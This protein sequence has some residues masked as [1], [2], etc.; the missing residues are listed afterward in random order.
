MGRYKQ[1][2]VWKAGCTSAYLR[3]DM[4][5]DIWGYRIQL[6]HKDNVDNSENT[7]VTFIEAHTYQKHLPMIPVTPFEPFFI[8]LTVHSWNTK[9]MLISQPRFTNVT[10]IFLT[11]AQK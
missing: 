4:R 9:N 5:V 11:F 1:C 6:L 7:T 2:K 3:A 10:T 8:K